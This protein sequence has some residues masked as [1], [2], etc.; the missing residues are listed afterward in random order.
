M[1]SLVSILAS[2][3]RLAPG[4]LALVE[5]VA[6]EA[7]ASEASRRLDRKNNEVDA[8]IKAVA[9]D[10]TIVGDVKPRVHCTK[11]TARKQPAADSASRVQ[12]GGKVGT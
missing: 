5:R 8:A 9:D 12:G 11:P 1:I 4:L 3:L 7:R 10:A 2:L 6:K